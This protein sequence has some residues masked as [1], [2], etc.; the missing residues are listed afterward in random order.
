MSAPTSTALPRGPRSKTARSAS[1]CAKWSA[2]DRLPNNRAPS[3]GYR[4]EILARNVLTARSVFA[5][6]DFM[7]TIYSADRARDTALLPPLAPR[8]EAHRLFRGAEQRA[9]LVDAF[10]LLGGGGGIIDD[11]GA[12]LHVHE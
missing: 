11:A 10:G 2:R 12:G 4:S 3:T 9:R 1:L 6:T 8:G 7:A 5:S